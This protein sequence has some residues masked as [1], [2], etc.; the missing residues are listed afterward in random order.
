MFIFLLLRQYILF[1]ISPPVMI[2]HFPRLLTVKL[3]CLHTFATKDIRKPRPI[4]TETATPAGDMPEMSL[5]ARVV[6]A[7]ETSFTALKKSFS[8]L[9]PMMSV[10]PER[11][12][13]RSATPE[14]AEEKRTEKAI[15]LPA[16]AL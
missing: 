2:M 14:S 12:V 5:P 15:R 10:L 13:I 3:I 6:T 1:T 11:A 9:S 8:S 7:S 16:D 4:I